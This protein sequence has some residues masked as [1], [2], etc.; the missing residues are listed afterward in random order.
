VFLI[1]NRIPSISVV[2]I[3]FVAIIVCFGS[4][5][6]VTI[7]LLFLSGLGKFFVRFTRAYMGPYDLSV[8]SCFNNQDWSRTQQAVVTTTGICRKLLALLFSSY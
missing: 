8:M 5:F 6:L 4:A 3:I 2:G 7:L 1:A